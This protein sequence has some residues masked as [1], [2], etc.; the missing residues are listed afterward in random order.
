MFIRIW[1]GMFRLSLGE[2][3]MSMCVDSY[4]NQVELSG[5]FGN[6]K[7][8]IINMELYWGGRID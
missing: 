5:L 3:K 8:S 1:W 4:C 2:I 6:G 7:N